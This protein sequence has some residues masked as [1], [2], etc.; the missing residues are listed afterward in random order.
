[1]NNDEL[2]T[3][4]YE[5]FGLLPPEPRGVDEETVFSVMKTHLTKG[6]RIPDDY[7]WYRDFPK[8]VDI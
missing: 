7:D 1:M 5:L 4:Y 3:A 8:D 2:I 6:E